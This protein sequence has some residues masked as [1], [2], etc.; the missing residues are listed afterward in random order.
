MIELV[1]KYRYV[2]D[3]LHWGKKW[4]DKDPGGYYHNDEYGNH[5]IIPT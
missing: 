1:D 5:A 2:E 3:P 4:S